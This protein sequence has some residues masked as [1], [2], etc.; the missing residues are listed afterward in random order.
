MRKLLLLSMAVV[1]ALGQLYA[2]RTITGKVTDDKGNPLPN[3]SVLVKGTQTGTVTKTDGSYSLTVLA[4]ARTLVISSVDM[5]PQ[6]F[7]I[8]SETTINASLKA[9]DK[10]L[11]EVVVVGYG[12]Q[13]KKEVTG[14]VSQ[15]NGNKLKDQ[16]LQ[17]FEQGLSGRAAG[18]NVSIPNGVLGNPPLIRVRGTNSISLSSAPLIVI[19]GVPSFTGDAGG[20]ASNNLL[21]DIN[22]ADI[23]SIEVLK[24]ASAAAI[25]GSRASA[26]VVLI[27]TKK[28]R[29]G[30]ARVNY[31]SWAGW[32]K[33]YNLIEVLNAQEFTDLKNEAL[34]NAGTPPNGTT[35][36]FYTM[37]D[38]NG[39]LIDTRWY[40]YIY[41]TGFSQNHTL[42]ISGA[43]DRTTYYFSGGYT[44][45]KGIFK[46]NNFK[47]MTGRFTLD[48][49]VNDWLTVGGTFNYSSSKNTGLN[50]GS[51][52]AAFNTSGAARLGFALAPNVSPYNPDGSYN[53]N[54]GSIGQGKNL[55][56][57]AFTN[58][59]LILDLNRFRSNGERI[60]GNVYGQVR[61]LK[62]L[63]FKTLYGIDHLSVVN[64]EFRNAIHGDG[65]QF[66]GAVSN[67]LQ[68]PFRWNWQNTLTYDT[69]FATNHGLNL[70]LGAEQQYTRTDNWGAD[71]R[72][73]TD[74][75]F[76]EFQGG[77][78]DIV[79]TGNTFAENFLQSYFGRINYDFKKKYFL[80]FNARRDGYSAFSEK[81]G[82]FYG[83]S[84]GWTISEEDF[85]KNS[86]IANT[87]SS[88]KMRGSYGMVGNFAGIGSYPYQ[89]LFNGGLYGAV[90]AIFFN[91]GGN[92]D[93]TWEKSK[94]LD[95]GFS[96]GFLRDRFNVEFAYYKNDISD[97][98]LAEPQSPSRGI[99]GNSI[100]R[101]VGSMVNKGIE[102]TLSGTIL[103]KKD[104]SWT[105]NLNITTL[106]NEVT[107][108]SNNNADILVSTGGLESPS[109]I[110]V[111][112]SIGSFLAVKTIG[113]N[114]ANGQRIFL[115]KDG[116]QVQ[117]NHAASA[118]TRWTKVSDGLATTPPNQVTDGVVIGPALPKYFGGFDNTLRYKGL[119]LNVLLFFSGGNYVYN[120]S[121]A[122]LH[123]NRN[124][125]NAK[126]NLERWQKPG[127]VTNWPRVVFGD[128]VSNGSALVISSNVE[129]GDFVKVRNISLGYTLPQN[130]VGRV[131]LS[132]VRVY[133]AALNVLTFTNYSGFDPEI[134]SNGEGSNVASSQVTNGAPSVD[135]NAAPLARTFNVGINIGF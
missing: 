57:L 92:P 52:G 12:T 3:A 2:Q 86:S 91:Q 95:L 70:L 106:K 88:F 34:T 128:N 15:I 115:M 110:R 20:T 119:D 101:N 33:A 50:T 121:K 67:T 36:G 48:Q 23:E 43:N 7:S 104:F 1:L 61:I 32:T 105:S 89:T 116:T 56:A 62:G 26:G 55:T 47:R 44:D 90:G 63:N 53:I 114:P 78:I 108:L 18:V 35:R 113:I 76:D 59:V 14:S 83:G 41:R 112:E 107:A 84:A 109:L 133:V 120:G 73:Q 37:T 25:Y 17:S 10:S 30:K 118:A 87:M 4:N 54:G 131:N 65:S 69:R 77:F 58:P 130:L 135:R 129:K 100:L 94:K 124:W 9:A 122:G 51:T 82:T 103:S 38:A 64:E 28:G 46:N 68:Q 81:W 31:E 49:K 39:K 42:S 8:G 117:Y 60:L 24:D 97:L 98:V 132:N 72:N 71:R 74:P 111:G 123:D 29:Q 21:G 6:E 134:Q 27:T 13:R 125:N 79:P 11:S 5:E 127:D 19:D 40:D 16:P 102:L 96:A 45:Q 126:D 75:F 80:S 99:P 22:P 66:G 85:W 93:L